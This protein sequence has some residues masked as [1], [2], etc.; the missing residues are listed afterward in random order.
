MES[1]I[2]EVERSGD[3][4]VLDAK[5]RLKSLQDAL[6][7]AKHDMAKQIRNY[8][9]LMNVKV[10][11]DIEIATYKKLLEGEENRFKLKTN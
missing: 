5:R 2:K 11:L 9:D 7:K 8:Q 3:E 4:A 10:A 1:Q 6:Q